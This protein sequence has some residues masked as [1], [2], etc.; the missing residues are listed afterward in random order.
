VQAETHLLLCHRYTALNP[1]RAGMVA[2]AA[3]YSWSSC[4]ANTLG[5]PNQILSLHSL[6]LA[7]GPERGERLEAHRALFRTAL[8][9]A[10]FAD[11]QLALSQNQPLGNDR[12]YAEIQAVT[13]R[14]REP[15]ERGRPR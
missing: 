1:V 7:L 10:P 9:D 12:F 14:R 15:R 4:R 2:D 3:D 6:D 13:G 5:A 8:D 11:L